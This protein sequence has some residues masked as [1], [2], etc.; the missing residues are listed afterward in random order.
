MNF[1][2]VIFLRMYFLLLSFT[3]S[4]AAYSRIYLDSIQTVTYY[5]FGITMSRSKFPLYVVVNFILMLLQLNVTSGLVSHTYSH[6]G[7]IFLMG[8]VAK[9]LTG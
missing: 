2:S 1:F 3:D 5:N 7:P 8:A 4:L 9:G 6:C